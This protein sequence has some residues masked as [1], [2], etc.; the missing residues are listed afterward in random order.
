MDSRRSILI[1]SLVLT[2]II[3]AIGVL[4]NHAFDFFRI[5]TIERVMQ[6]HELDTE[7]Y[8]VER[9]FTDVFGGEACDVMQTR[10]SDLKKE[11]NTVGNDLGS[12]SRFSFFKKKDFDY[13]KRKY[14]LLEL[15]FFALIKR[16]NKECGDLYLPVVFFYEID[17][18]PSER[19]GFIL[20]DLSKEYEQEVIV[21]TLDKDYKDEP[22]VSLLASVYN[23][24]TAPTLIIGEKKYE[25]FFSTGELNA[26]IIKFLRRA[27][28][29]AKDIDFKFTINATGIDEGV[30][31]SQLESIREDESASLWARG[32]ATLVLGRLLKNDDLV[33]KSLEYF[34]KINSSDPEEQAL[35]YETFAA[36][37]CGLN[38]NAFLREAAAN[39]RKA[40]NFPRAELE[41]KIANSERVIH[42]FDPL[43]LNNSAQLVPLLNASP[44]AKSVVL[45]TTKVV[46]DENSVVLS[47]VDRV[48]RDW[49]GGQLASP[50]GPELLATFSERRTYNQSELLP[51]IGWHE[52]ARLKE[53]KSINFTHFVGPGT[54]V[55]RSGDKWFAVDDQ[56]IFRFEVPKDKLLYPTTRFLRK[57][58]AIIID[59]HGI[60]MLVEQAIRK[61]ATAVVG[62]C[63]N[64]SK[65]YAAEYLAKRNI[66]VVCFTD[67]YLFQ[68]IGHD[69]NILGS[70]PIRIFG[71]KAIL[72]NQPI[73]ISVKEKIL[74]VNSSDSVFSLWYYQTPAS[75][76]SV[77]E[78]AL[79]INVTYFTLN[80]FNQMDLAVMAARLTNAS[81]IATRI[82]NSADYFA[83]KGWLEENSNNKAIL[84]H[85]SA[86][87][88][89][90][91]LFQEFPKQTTFDDP[92]PQVLT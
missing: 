24:S 72:G 32:D 49:L 15:K 21:L 50:F 3:F 73:K 90:Y 61:N 23:V 45:G 5:S 63:D 84:F 10:I 37:D 82:F 59:N 69:L 71:G 6:A 12:Y 4:L 55:A 89:G 40:G 47:Q 31:M 41:E 29:Y 14:F 18:D 67:K 7:A 48:Y 8:H 87:P 22:L 75:Y 83:V 35:V 54:L 76:M 78:D 64:P 25:G 30:L 70:P 53:L 36:L 88:Y 60:N 13:L 80:D 16:L 77:L 68:A 51:E 79:P 86:Y 66:S 81:V 26:T 28:P 38:R 74:A 65:I 57:D 2:I 44:N 91:K 17:D 9:L 85:S 46:L 39:W 43:A 42:S 27:D 52:G 20:E 11:I 19:Q 58:L 62:C 1:G 33:C 92:N 34:G 56:G